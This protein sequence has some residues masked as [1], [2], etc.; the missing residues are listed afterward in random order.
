MAEFRRKWIEG[1]AA[2][3]EALI[4]TADIQSLADLANSFEVVTEMRVVPF[5]RASVLRLA[6]TAALPLAP[7]LLT[8]IPLDELID[9]AVRVFL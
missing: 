4:G 3:D 9:R 5:G 2:K 8:M 1:H 6:M 7:L